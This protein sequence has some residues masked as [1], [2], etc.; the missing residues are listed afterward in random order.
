MTAAK[1]TATGQFLGTLDYVSPEQLSGQPVGGAC[2]QYSL[3]CAAFE[4]FSGTAPFERDTGMAVM[5]AHI[6]DTPPSLTSRRS[7]LPEPLDA[8]FVRALAKAPADR[9]GSCQEFAEAQDCVG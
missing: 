1:I 9:F 4:L 5:Y 2:D 3:A 8:V 7:E 6:H